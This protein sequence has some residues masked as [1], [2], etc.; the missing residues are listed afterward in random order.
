MFPTGGPEPHRPLSIAEKGIEPKSFERWTL[1]FGIPFVVSTVL[2][3]CLLAAVGYR[4]TRL[5]MIFVNVD[6]AW[7]AETGQLDN[8]KTLEPVGCCEY[9]KALFIRNLQNIILVALIIVCVICPPG[10][11]LAWG[12]ALA[13]DQ[14]SPQVGF[15]ITCIGW[16]GLIV[17]YIVLHWKYVLSSLSFLSLFSLF[18]LCLPVSTNLTTS[19]G[20]T[21]GV[22]PAYRRGASPSACCPSALSRWASCT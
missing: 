10:M 1:S 18:S 8:A 6:A 16:M 13:I 4:I 9:T 19:T 12:I 11:L 14:P 7:P 17:L 22:G 21:C 15:F 5:P 3:I 2:A 20:T